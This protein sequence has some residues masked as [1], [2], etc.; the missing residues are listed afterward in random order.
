MGEQVDVD[1][2]G[3]RLSNEMERRGESIKNQ[4]LVEDEK[5]HCQPG[6]QDIVKRKVEVPTQYTIAYSH[7]FIN[8]YFTE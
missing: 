2:Q 7:L 1:G 8:G 4:P 6:V 3:S 5:P